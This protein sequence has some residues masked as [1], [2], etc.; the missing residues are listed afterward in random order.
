MAKKKRTPLL[1]I[2]DIL[3]IAM[4]AVGLYLIIKPMVI[5]WQQDRMTQNLLQ[6]YENGDGTIYLDPSALIVD[7]EDVDY[8]SDNE[9]TV[10]TDTS[11]DPSLPSESA[12]PSP[13]PAPAKVV[14]KAIGRIRIPCI[15][16]D[17]PIAEGSTVYN[18]RVAIGHYSNSVGLG[19]V[20][21][22]IF[23]G[24]RMY[25]YGRHFNRL[26][27]V[28]IGDMIIIEDK[29]NRYTYTVDQIDR[30]LPSE[31]VTEFNAPVEGSRITLVT[32]DP[33]RVASH[34]LLV[35]GVLTSTEPLS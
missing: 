8:F 28:A 32:C 13:T 9:P 26:N 23:L 21:N 34:R 11:L 35:K 30:I 25:S 29:T 1:I 10:T 6:N 14:I 4:A 24:H 15:N 31:L 20:G 7:G 5:H 2:L 19:Q 33:I 12:L 16:V 17:M 3:I 27:E 18:L 22:S